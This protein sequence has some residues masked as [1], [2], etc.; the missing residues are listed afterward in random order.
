MSSDF[1][2]LL[3]R[4]SKAGV[5]FVLIGGFAGVTYGCTMVTEDV[6][7]CCDFK[8]SNLLKL[9]K[10]IEDLHPVH[11]MTPNKIPLKLTEENCKNMKNLYLDTDLGQLDCVSYVQGVGDFGKVKAQSSSVAAD[12]VNY[13]VLNLGVLIEAKKAMGRPRDIEAVIQLESIKE[14]LNKKDRQ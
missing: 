2:N 10:A 8:P 11:R 1:Y 6:D 5:D 14:L 4:L 9:Q 12:D 7:V 13:P 3:K